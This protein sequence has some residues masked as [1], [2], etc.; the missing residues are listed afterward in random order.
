YLLGSVAI[1]RGYFN[2]TSKS[3]AL[4]E[5]RKNFTYIPTLGFFHKDGLSL[6]ATGNIVNNNSKLNLYQIAVSPGYDYLE[7]R[8]LATGF[9]YTRFF[10]KDTLSFYTTPLQNELYGY[11]TYRKWWIRPTVALSYGWGS[12][13]DY[14]EREELIQDLRLRRS[15][16]T[17]INSKESISDFSVITS[18][19]HDF[20]WL[21]VFS[22]KDHFRLTPQLSFISGTQKFGFNQSANTYATILRTG[23]NVLYNSENV[24]LDDQLDFQPLSLTMFLRGEY[25]IGKFFIQ[26]QLVFD[27]YFPTDQS[28][29]S[30]LFS[31]NVGMIF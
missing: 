24:Y 15:G 31:F 7:N 9:T 18:L 20:Y 12:R 27:Y 1:G 11:F 26:P 4:I 19:R 5:T 8:D 30:T 16:V 3:T 21:S 6:T 14:M 25:S 10:T 2:Y 17:R 13:T 22:Y 23:T 28:N 29:F